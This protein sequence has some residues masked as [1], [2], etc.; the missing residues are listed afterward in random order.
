MKFNYSKKFVKQ[1]KKLPESLKDAFETRL[2][3]FV[4]DKYNP[5]LKNHRL[6]GDYKGCQSLNISGD[7]RLIFQSDEENGIMLLIE[8][9]DHHQLYGK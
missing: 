2:R 6:K 4:V 5:I 9:G 7:F 8:I 3:L 1:F